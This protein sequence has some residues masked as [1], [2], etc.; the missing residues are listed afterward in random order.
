MS[1]LMV[2]QNIILGMI[3]KKKVT[4]A[5]PKK[6][7]FNVPEG[8]YRGVTKDAF[9]MDEPYKD[10]TD[11]TKGQALVDFVYWA[12]TKGQN[13][14]TQLNYSPLPT[15]IAGGLSVSVTVQSTTKPSIFTTTYC[16]IIHS[17]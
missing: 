5:F 15:S 7:N 2:D 4:L 1:E 16:S 8:T 13:E 11:K 9:V 6:E 3:I 17:N 10:Q 14:V 12:L